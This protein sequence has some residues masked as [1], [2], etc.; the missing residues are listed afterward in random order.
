M[1]IAKP[2]S[3]LEKAL[4]NGHFAVTAELGPPK[5]SG[6][7]VVER[8]G[9]SL[10]GAADAINITDNQ[11]AITRMSSLA[12]SIIAKEM[13]LDPVMQI[14]CRDRNRLAIQA[15][16]LGAAAFGIGNILALS[17]D[18]QKFGNHPTAKNVYDLDSLNLI[19]TL[20]KMRDEKMFQSGDTFRGDVPIFIGA[21]ENPFGDPF[22][23]RVVRLGKKV[24]AGA[25]FIQTQGIFDVAKFGRFM[26]MVRDQGLDQKVFILA[27]IIPLKSAGAARYMRDEVAGV[28]MPDE[29]VNR[30]AG[31]KDA[32]EEGIKITMEIIQQVKE[33]PG[34]RGIHIM[35]VNWEEIVP[36]IVQEAGLMPR[37]VFQ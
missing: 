21:A 33:M 13:G 32:I 26:Q 4:R 9:E 30:M 11:T 16:V 37:P 10:R 8:K 31:A 19:A 3:N 2:V 23:F 24:R 20:K 22:E 25:D 28:G 34:V 27:G 36:R 7:K 5:G 14:T 29:V 6:R 35:A 18:H 1:S 15:D 12:T 17:G